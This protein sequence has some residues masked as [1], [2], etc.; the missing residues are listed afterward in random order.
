MPRHLT[1]ALDQLQAAP[2]E[3][4]YERIA[5]RCWGDDAENDDLTLLLNYLSSA[6]SWHLAGLRAEPEALRHAAQLWKRRPYL[7]GALERWVLHHPCPPFSGLI[8]RLFKER[9]RTYVAPFKRAVVDGEALLYTS[10]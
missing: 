8:T 6:A 1:R 2:A 7:R 10:C 9:G 5:A 3:P 4:L